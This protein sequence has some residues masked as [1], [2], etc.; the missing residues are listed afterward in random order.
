MVVTFD[1]R[2]GPRHS[3]AAPG[4]HGPGG[5]RLRYLILGFVSTIDAS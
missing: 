1:W 4:G 2:R 3:G 5:V